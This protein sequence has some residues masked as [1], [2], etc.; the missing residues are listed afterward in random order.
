VTSG[1][2]FKDNKSSLDWQA[3]NTFNFAIKSTTATKHTVTMVVSVRVAINKKKS[4]GTAGDFI[5][6]CRCSIILHCPQA[7]EMGCGLWIKADDI[8]GNVVNVTNI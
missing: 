5:K 7:T 8:I 1:A 6:W 3:N 2:A 4:D